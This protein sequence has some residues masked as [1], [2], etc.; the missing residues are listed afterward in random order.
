MTDTYL[1]IK[2]QREAYKEL[3]GE[4][5]FG[6]LFGF[7]LFWAGILINLPIYGSNL[8]NVI[9]CISIISIGLISILFAI[10]VPTFLRWPYK[11][12]MYIGKKI[13][14]VIFLLLLAVI[15]LSLVLPVGLIKKKKR[16]NYGYFT[17][18]SDFED[19]ENTFEDIKILDNMNINYRTKSSFLRNIYI[20][21]GTLVRNKRI[22]L[23]PA[24]VTLVIV[25]LMLIFTAS[26]IIINFFIYTLF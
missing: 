8:I 24:A 3:K 4:T 19:D 5:I 16:K 22:F 15:Y 25:G 7:I 17:W 10:I 20:L 12:F 14:S 23:I 2:Q 1:E 18:N 6:H 9:I 13:G 11:A 21:F 26:N